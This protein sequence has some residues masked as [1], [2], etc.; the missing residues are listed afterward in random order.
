MDYFGPLI[1]FLFIFS[2][3]FSEDIFFANYV[4][5]RIPKPS[6]EEVDQSVKPLI[7][8]N[9]VGFWFLRVEYCKQKLVVFYNGF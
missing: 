8:K 2:F 4:F 1:Y 5:R 9:I 6:S 3:L 7:W